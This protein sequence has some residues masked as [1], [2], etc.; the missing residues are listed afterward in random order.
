ML[1]TGV[2]RKVPELHFLS[3]GLEHLTFVMSYSR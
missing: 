2:F 1:E 3:P